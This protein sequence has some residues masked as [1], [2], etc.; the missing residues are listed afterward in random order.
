MLTIRKTQRHV[1]PACPAVALMLL[2]LLAPGRLAR[3]VD[4]AWIGPELGSWNVG[5]N[6]STTFAP[7]A[8]FNEAGVISNFTTAVLS[9]HTKS[10]DF[11]GSDVNVAGVR[12]G[13]TAGSVGGLRII[14]GGNLPCV[15]AAGESGAIA[16]GIAGQGV[17]TVVGNGMIS[18]PSLT[19][20]GASGSSIALA[21]TASL[22]VTGTAALQRTTTITGP[23]VNF[24]A[25]DDVTLGSASL[26]I[27]EILHASLHSPLKSAGA[28]MLDG[29]FRP[30][31]SGGVTPALGDTWDIID[32]QS[33]TGAFASL[34]TSA[35]PALPPGQSY[36]L[37][38]ATG[39]V[40]GQVLQL[41]V[42]VPEPSAL[43]VGIAGAILVVL[44]RR[45]IPSGNPA[46]SPA[47]GAD[48]AGG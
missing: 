34:D 9:A 45:R 20:G 21:D 22:T 47:A 16:V 19:L 2:A 13:S 48:R 36:E 29:T 5:G 7:D 46:A 14:S 33:I 10:G 1:P 38:Q 32:A 4:N 15:P 23:T 44:A 35:A 42:V 28:A 11:P 6:W 37:V 8:A 30:T 12:L 40:H 18:G 43:G 27:G 25:G 26:L 24:S 41:A 39:G 17:L 31:F 3:A